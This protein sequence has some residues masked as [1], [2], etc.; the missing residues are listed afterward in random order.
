[1]HASGEP[2][3]LHVTGGDRHV[4]VGRDREPTLTW[5]ATT[6]QD[7][8]DFYGEPF[9]FTLKANTVLMDGSVVGV[10]GVARHP[11]WGVFFTDY[12]PELE[13]H[14]SSVTVW[15]AVKDAMTFV[16]KYRGP[17]M[18]IADH[19]EGCMNLHRLGFSHLYG[20]WYGWL[21]QQQ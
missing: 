1:M 4:S 7:I 18:S 12:K 17:V 10:V 9:K 21:G 2:E 16:R 13:P 15:R 8:I 6:A 14:L 5:R 19:V 20:A 11:E 3:A